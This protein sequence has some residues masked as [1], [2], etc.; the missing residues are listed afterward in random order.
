MRSGCRRAFGTEQSTTMLSIRVIRF[1]I[2][3]LIGLTV[4]LGLYRFFTSLGVH[5]LA[6]SALALLLALVVGFVLQKYW[7]FED[8]SHERAHVQLSLYMLVGL[9]N[10]A[11]NSVVV[12][13]LVGIFGVY[14]LLAQAIG[15]GTVA[16]VSFFIYREFIF[17]APP[18]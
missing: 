11:V 4:N 1:L 17:T 13:V 2:S 5:Y 15:A 18:A 7:T 14:Y 3:G 10:L 6:G 8:R 9:G 16:I 12:Y